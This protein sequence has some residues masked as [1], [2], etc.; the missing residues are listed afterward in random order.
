MA[1]DGRALARG[2]ANGVTEAL[3]TY[4]R[5]RLERGLGADLSLMRVHTGPVADRLARTLG[6]EAFT[7]G[8]DV[9]FRDGAYAPDTP[10]GLWLLAHEAA[11]V[12]QQAGARS[13]DDNTHDDPWER[14]ADRCAD[15]ILAGRRAP[16]TAYGPPRVPV[17]QRHVSFEHRLLGDAPTA[18]LVAVSTNGPTRGQFLG[19][20]IELLTLWQ[21][22]PE[23]VTES[24]INAKCPWI[25]T[26]R[27]GP[28]NLLVTYGELNALPDYLADAGALDTVDPTIVLPIL[29]VIRQEGFNQLTSLLTGGNPNVTFAQAACEPWSLSLV[30]NIVETT[31]LD[32]LTIG[33]GSVG[34][35]HYQGLL[36]R[37]ACH[38]AP[39]SWYRWQ[40]S[41][42]IAR[43][44]A[45]QAHATGD[46]EMARR[47]WVHHGYADHFLEDSF[48]AGHLVN[49]TLI[50]QWFI[51]W[52]AQQ[53][54]LPVADWDAIKNITE[55]RQPSLAGRW[56]YDPSFAG[57]SNDPQTD[58]EAAS[59]VDR[60]V[61]SGILADGPVDQLAAYKNYLTFLASAVAQLGSATLHDYYNDNSVW[62][63]SAAST[64]PYELWGDSTLLSGANGGA[65]VQATSETAQLSQEALL[66]I[67]GTGT[68]S[69]TT[70]QIRAHFPT[71][72][73]PDRD[74]LHSLETWATT[75]KSFCMDRF[76]EF[77][78]TIKTALL[79]LAS[80]RLG[81]VSQDQ[82]FTSVWSASLPG[83]GFYPVNSLFH[84]D[85][86]FSASDGYVYELDPHSGAVLHTLRL[87]TDGDTTSLAT[88]GTTL[89]AGVSGHAYAIALDDW[90]GYA[91]KTT[92]NLG[93]TLD[94]QVNL[95]VSGTRLFAGSD[96]SVYELAPTTGAVL[97][98]TE[99]T[100]SLGGGVT[101]VSTDGT[102]LFAGVHGYAYGVRLS[103]WT[104]TWETPDN[105]GGTFAYEEVN[106]FVSGTRLFAGSDGYVYELAPATGQ[107]LRSLQLTTD[108]G[109]DVTRMATDGTYLFAGVHGYAYGVRL[110]DWG[111]YAWSRSVGGTLAY[112]EV[113][114]LSLDG[115]LFAGSNGHVYR[116]T[117]ETGTV[118]Y[119]Q[120]LTS[121]VGAGDYDTSI[122]TDGTFLYAGVHGY[123]YKVLVTTPSNAT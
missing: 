35:N 44:L 16:S 77:G 87:T 26:L 94:E 78:P 89:Y 82:D 105:L 46:P 6:A 91:W 8:S 122:L 57:P 40:A 55:A 100:S 38:F 68:T 42:L 23:Q 70:A 43:D 53:T 64:T 109:G 5:K 18:D 2:I 79:G 47:A 95:L 102:Y 93:G 81:L 71:K 13:L 61:G 96:G 22:D 117:P 80:P 120:L 36:A 9:F 31:A 103:D 101:R 10:Q 108:V 32:T 116:L 98:S 11:H 66:E 63:S 58:Q 107:I 60:V 14:D 41:H 73:G 12:A 110:N 65:G 67:L 51:E 52:A 1:N 29:Q 27:L 85:R 56:L 24:D 115:R 99:L 45:A 83:S 33:L 119:G 62:A 106:V 97:H 20:Q 118:Q 90:S 54:L 48:A 4:L 112:E 123:A 88:N 39:F 74:H 111:D 34:Q 21:D 49:K 84:G 25:R 7:Y 3:P 30:N 37:N 19:N 69:I 121:T 50:M 114:V 104:T 75:Q 86:L 59:L 72:A 92:R 76:G 113:S 15:R 28:G 17:I